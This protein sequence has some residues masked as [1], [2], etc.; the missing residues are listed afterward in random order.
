MESRESA[1]LLMRAWKADGRA[2]ALVGPGVATP[3]HVCIEV[4]KR[5]VSLGYGYTV[6]VNLSK[7]AHT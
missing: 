1:E 6:S 2:Q 5:S 7:L 4:F 3:L